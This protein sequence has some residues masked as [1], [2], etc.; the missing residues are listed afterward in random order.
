MRLIMWIVQ[1]SRVA[2]SRFLS[3]KVPFR[4]G[5]DGWQRRNR[6]SVQVPCLAHDACSDCHSQEFCLSF[7]LYARRHTLKRVIM[8]FICFI[9]LNKCELLDDVE[10][11]MYGRLWCIA[12]QASSCRA[13]ASADARI[14]GSV[15]KAK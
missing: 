11:T 8:Y 5:W 2:E 14:V 4:L 7:V 9:G 6:V 15:M 12:R 1:A 10:L 13:L 3:S